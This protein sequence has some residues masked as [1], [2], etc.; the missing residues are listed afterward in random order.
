MT[1]VGARS[2]EELAGETAAPADSKAL[3]ARFSK[4]PPLI[5]GSRM[6]SSTTATTYVPSEPDC[7]RSEPDGD[8]A[9]L[10]EHESGDV[11]AESKLAKGPSFALTSKRLIFHTRIHSA[12]GGRPQRAR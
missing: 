7:D 9:G 5:P 12:V 2:T 8:D 4:K 1:A 11:Q 3:G 10:D 6:R